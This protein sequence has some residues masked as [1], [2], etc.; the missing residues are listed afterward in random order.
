M[1]D[2]HFVQYMDN[3]GLSDSH[4]LAYIIDWLAQKKAKG[5]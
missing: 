5:R 3:E 2:A 4:S 1:N